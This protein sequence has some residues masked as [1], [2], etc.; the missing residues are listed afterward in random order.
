MMEIEA[1]LYDV[2]PAGSVS[3]LP[4][5]RQEQTSYSQPYPDAL[6][7]N[8]LHA[9]TMYQTAMGFYKYVQNVHTG[10]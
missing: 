1:G 3:R 6:L 7:F 9:F 8:T 2:A 5:F 4:N 10:S